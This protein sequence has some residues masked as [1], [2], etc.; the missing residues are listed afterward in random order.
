MYPAKH[1]MILPRLALDPHRIFTSSLTS[2]TRRTTFPAPSCPSSIS[3]TRF[4]PSLELTND[5]RPFN[6][7]NPNSHLLPPLPLHGTSCTS[8]SSKKLTPGSAPPPKAPHP[9]AFLPTLNTHG[10]YRPPEHMVR[11]NAAAWRTTTP[12][13]GSA[14]GATTFGSSRSSHPTPSLPLTLSTLSYSPA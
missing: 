4:V 2:L 3:F 5:H 10:R 7:D 14:V 6:V 11:W 8:S 12:P 1:P 9:L 13:S